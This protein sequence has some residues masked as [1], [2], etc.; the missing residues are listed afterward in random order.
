MSVIKIEGLSKKYTLGTVGVKSLFSKSKLNEFWALKDVSFEINQGDIL[1]VVGRNG[2]GKSTLLK[3]ISKITHPTKGRVEINGTISSLL[4][5]GTGFH[6]ELTGRENV[7]MNGTILGMSRAQIKKK[8]DEIVA[9]AELEKFIDTPV[10]R[11]SSGM[12]VRLGFSVSAHLNTEILILDEVLAVGDLDFQNKCIR[13]MNEIANS[14]KTILFVSHNMGSIKSLCENSIYL[15]DGE[16]V[17]YNKTTKVIN[18]YINDGIENVSTEVD[19]NTSKYI[20]RAVKSKGEVVLSKLRL[21]NN[22]NIVTINKS[23]LLELEFEAINSNKNYE[24]CFNIKNVEGTILNVTASTLDKFEIKSKKGLNII[25]TEISSFKLFPGKYLID[26]WI[27]KVNAKEV[28]DYVKDCLT[29]IVQEDVKD[30]NKLFYQYN[31]RNSQTLVN[32]IWR[33]KN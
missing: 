2:A 22:S 18:K 15:K 21:E 19:F 10:K 23:L 20:D 5:V 25:Q 29:I 3:I 9:F 12:Y 27:K 16:L 14:G 11:Y 30:V 17:D 33:V 8:F 28:I 4:E 1:G 6:P 24:I 31:S 32:S 7:Y 26:V 13:K